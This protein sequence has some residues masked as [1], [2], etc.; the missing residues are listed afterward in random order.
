MIRGASTIVIFM[1]RFPPFQMCTF[2]LLFRLQMYANLYD[3]ITTTVYRILNFV[4]FYRFGIIRIFSRMQW[5]IFDCRKV[6]KRHTK[7][8]LCIFEKKQSAHQINLFSY[9][10]LALLFKCILVIWYLS[11]STLF[12]RRKKIHKEIIRS[13]FFFEWLS[14]V[15]YFGT[16]QLISV[17]CPIQMTQFQ[18]VFSCSQSE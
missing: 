3:K 12:I 6:S 10:S 8:V 17:N 16:F 14:R 15:G 1:K 4:L 7:T 9:W 5:N 18:I 13:G 2:F 11:S